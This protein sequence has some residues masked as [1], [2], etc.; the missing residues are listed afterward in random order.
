MPLKLNVPFSE[1]DIAKEKGAFWDSENKTWFVPDHKDINLFTKWIDSG[2]VTLIA[3]APFWLGH[4]QKTCWKCKNTTEVIA[5]ASNNFFTYDYADDDDDI[6]EWFMQDYFSFFNMPTY[7][8][9][10]ILDIIY[11]RY[12]FFKLGFSKA[13][14]DKYWANHCKCC[15]ALQGDFFMHE[16]PGGEF[17]PI[18]IDGYKAITLIEIPHKFDLTLNASYSWASNEKEILKYCRKAKW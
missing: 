11:S 18:D 4:T 17:S 7:I 13:I 10:E 2:I 9:K 8:E 14:N 12:P 16:E 5:F 6:K 3:K 1:K 15:N